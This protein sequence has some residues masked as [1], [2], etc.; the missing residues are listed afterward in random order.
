MANQI[1]TFLDS[2]QLPSRTGQD[3]Q[4]F[5][6]CMAYVMGNLPTW[7]AEINTVLSMFNA[8]A[9]GG[10][11]AIPFTFD[12]L[13]QADGDAGPGKLRLSSAT[14]NASTVLRL[15]LFSSGS[16]DFTSVIDTFDAS[17]SS[18][19]GSIRLVKQGDITKWLTFN[20]TARATPTGYRNITVVNTGSSVASPFTNGDG[21]LLYFQRTGDVGAPGQ[22]GFSNLLV[23][24]TTQTWTPPAGVTKA[25]ITV[26]DG[27]Y[28]GAT[29]NASGTSS[30]GRG[31]D[32]SVSIRTVNPAVTYTATI[33]SGGVGPAAGS[34]ASPVAGGASSFSGS[35][36]TT[37]T[38]A[39]GDLNIP[40]GAGA[41]SSTSNTLGC[42]GGTL[43]A[44]L[45][46]ANSIGVAPGQG[47]GGAG[48]GVAGRN[49]AAGAI[50]IRY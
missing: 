24:T 22:P 1:T 34:T 3:Q 2:A 29:N 25:E 8:I 17:T 14:Q 9:A 30:S 35:G 15:D 16:Q 45:G 12:G 48:A 37:L 46:S 11:Y 5:D 41:I 13:S 27:G 42:G 32:T 28:S 26:I 49:G 43:Y 38:T 18:V 7:G 21:L 31:G 19:K 44:P 20:V 50:I 47:G 33:G 4:T 6:N 10:A 40:G 36:L 23:I 39:N